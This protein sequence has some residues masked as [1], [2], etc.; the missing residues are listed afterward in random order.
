MLSELNSSSVSRSDGRRSLPRL[1]SGTRGEQ[2]GAA[3]N[4]D[5][6]HLGG[7]WIRNFHYP[8]GLPHL[9]ESVISS[10]ERGTRTAAARLNLAETRGLK[11]AWLSKYVYVAE[12]M[13]TDLNTTARSP[14]LAAAIR[15]FPQLWRE[16]QRTIA[17]RLPSLLE[18]IALVDEDPHSLAPLWFEARNFCDYVWEQHFFLMYAAIIPWC[19]L[20]SLQQSLLSELATSPTPH[21]QKKQKMPHQDED[22]EPVISWALCAAG[23][24]IRSPLMIPK[25]P[26]CRFS[27]GV[28]PLPQGLRSAMDGYR[29]AQAARAAS[30]TNFP[31]WNEAHTQWLDLSGAVPL[32]MITERIATWCLSKGL[33]KAHDDLFLLWPHQLES[34]LV[35]P[36]T[37][38][39]PLPQVGLP[40]EQDSNPEPPLTLGVAPAITND[41]IFRDIHGASRSKARHVDSRPAQ[42][43]FRVWG[44]PVSPGT[45]R[46]II[47]EVRDRSDLQ[48]LTPNSIV[49]CDALLPEWAYELGTVQG[50]LA[51]R[52]GALSHS[53]TVCR[54]RKVPCIAGL[55]DTTADIREGH[56]VK[57]SGFSGEI[58]LFES[59]GGQHD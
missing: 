52:G 46:G 53:A 30:T 14:E 47:V 40:G 24:D 15:S 2:H 37:Q 21:D 8:Q 41:P 18:R 38:P 6:N 35:D 49:L 57:M 13:S 16:T 9:S 59:N 34:W 43:S 3:E 26:P 36:S 12:W 5:R 54:E 39:F 4:E 11:F 17:S 31:L 48:R 27:T 58:L 19:D 29:Y 45:A 7:F 51:R 25:S 10:I 28:L 22:P 50:C 20:Q 33:T 44:D 42:G 1:I 55:G 32:R 23:A 56:Y